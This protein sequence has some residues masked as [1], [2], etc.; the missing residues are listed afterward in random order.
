MLPVDVDGRVD[1]AAVVEVVFLWRTVPPP[2]PPEG[3]G[4]PPALGDLPP[5]PTVVWLAGAG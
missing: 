1:L 5:A 3:L 4:A 2:L